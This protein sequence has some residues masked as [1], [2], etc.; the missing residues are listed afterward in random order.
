MREIELLAPARDKDCG[1]AAVKCGADAVYIGAD[2][3]GARSA[4]SNPVS[5]LEELISYAH[6]YRARVY[7]T[8]NTLLF[9]HEL[10]DAERLIREVYDMGAD[11]LIVQDMGILEMDLPPI[12]LIAST[13]T[14]N[15]T[16]ERVKFLEDAGF[17]R[18]ILARE[19]TL[20]EIAAIRDNTS[21]ELETFIHGALCVS[22]S[23]QCYISHACYGRSGNR[24]E[25]AQPC[26]MTYSLLDRDKKL[27][28]KDKYL[29]SLKDLNLSEHLRELMDAGVTSFKIEGRLKD[30]NYVKNVV[31]YYRRRLD[32][33]I[34]GSD[35]RRSSSGRSTVEFTP[36][37]QKSFNRGFSTYFLNGRRQGTG[38]VHTQKSIGEPL[39]KV[40][41][42][43][44]DWFIIDGGKE[45]NN[46]DGICYIDDNNILAGTNI[47]FSEGN[48]VFPHD[49]RYIKI[50]LTVY[51][52]SDHDFIKELKRK[53]IERK[54]DIDLAFEESPDGFVLRAADEDGITA[55][56]ALTGEKV[57]AQN[58][59]KAA[60]TVKK[61]LLKFGDEIFHV[62]DFR[63]GLSQSYFF[64]VS[65]LND[66]RRSLVSVLEKNRA[67]AFPRKEIPIVKNSVP[68]PVTELDFT[69]NVLNRLASRFYE[70]HGV[71]ILRP[72]TESG[73]DLK[74]EIVMTTRY[75]L[76]YELGLCGKHPVKP[77]SIPLNT[78]DIREPL[79]LDDGK[80]KFRLEFDCAKCRM[81]IVLDS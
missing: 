6:R 68:F 57:P 25:C 31:S 20:D 26:R 81:N 33:L 64:P 3:F 5:E 65:V 14:H 38:S 54:I 4:A 41:T 39:G 35:Y 61:Q 63:V 1:I 76:K 47:L 8:L 15:H 78:G 42:K 12:P 23:G 29:L 18:A 70:R 11:G 49:N 80:R 51:R 67:N 48:R 73:L 30:E 34:D 53:K 59:E 37:P 21:I 46:G 36:D 55:E 40:I 66:A 9:D 50:G 69:G 77:E 16:P 62:R 72:A 28:I 45:L 43:G 56:Y 75:C 74:G 24:G 22:Y 27:L 7:I 79:Y 32:S 2:K 10:S 71:K 60:E 44:R 19:L 17:T 13:Q 58:P 52:N